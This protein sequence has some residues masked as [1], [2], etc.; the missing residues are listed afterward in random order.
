VTDGEALPGLIRQTHRKSKVASADGAYDTK[1]C[2][3]ELRRKKIKPSPI[4]TA[5]SRRLLASGICRTKSGRREA[6]AYGERVIQVNCGYTDS[7]EVIIFLASKL[8]HTFTLA[9]KISKL[10][11]S[12]N[13]KIV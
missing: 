13:I 10:C 11:I 6:S 4:P 9:L 5:N 8:L 7:D 3:D 2:H 1:Q 12:Y